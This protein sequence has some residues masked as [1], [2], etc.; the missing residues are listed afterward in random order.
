MQADRDRRRAPVSAKE[1]GAAQ[2]MRNCATCALAGSDALMTDPRNGSFRAYAKF[3]TTRRLGTN[4]AAKIATPPA[5][6]YGAAG[7]RSNSAPPSSGPSKKPSDLA[8]WRSPN[9]SPWRLSGVRLEQIVLMVGLA[10]APPALNIELNR[11]ISP[12]PGEKG[13][14]SSPTPCITNPIRRRFGNEMRA[15]IQANSRP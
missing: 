7:K 1:E 9:S 12:N 3:G 14:R 4:S 13:V 11:R 8:A 6:M 2:M 5:R 10:S 15:E